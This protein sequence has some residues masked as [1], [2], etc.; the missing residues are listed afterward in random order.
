MPGMSGPEVCLALWAT[1][2]SQSVYVILLTGKEGT[3]NLVIGLR[4][5]ADDYIVKPFEPA[6]LRARLNV[7]IRVVLMQQSLADRVRE[8]EIAL[9]HVKRLQ[10]LVP[11]CA[12]CKKVRDDQNYWRQ[13]E[14]YVSERSEAR[15]THGICPECYEKVGKEE[16]Y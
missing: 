6:E 13:V 4:S 1:P 7:G 3:T 9:A 16:V 2:A 5:G 14:E 12:W 8:L 10:G 11:M 15:F